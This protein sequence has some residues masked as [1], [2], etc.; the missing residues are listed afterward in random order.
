MSLLP[1]VLGQLDADRNIVPAAALRP[2]AADAGVAPL[3]GLPLDDPTVADRP[4]IVAKID[5]TDRG[6]PQ[7]ALSQADI[8]FETEI[9]GGFTRLVGVWHSQTPEVLGPVRSGRTTDIAVFSSFNT[10]I[11]VWSGA[12]RVHR[13]LIR[14]Y[15]MVD[16]GAAT[17]NEYFRDPDRPG[18]YDL[19][20]DPVRAVGYRRRRWRRRR[21]ARPLRVPR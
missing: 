5:N 2:A 19:M 18:T 12:N 3:T 20:T 17:R 7:E 4:A 11:F 21:T 16:L 9:E 8:V 1:G 10:P 15:E 13:A 6:R 14:R